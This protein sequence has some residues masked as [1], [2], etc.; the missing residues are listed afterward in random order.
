[1]ATQHQI[2]EAYRE[3]KATFRKSFG[4]HGPTFARKVYVIKS[5]PY[6]SN[7]DKQLWESWERGYV[8]DTR[9]VIASA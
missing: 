6:Y 5:N 1:M 2:D 4:S 8:Q 7:P 9:R 3:G